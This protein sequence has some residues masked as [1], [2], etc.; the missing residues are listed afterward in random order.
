MGA[1]LITK[2]TKYADKSEEK[3]CAYASGNFRQSN[4]SSLDMEIQGVIYA[5]NKFKLYLNK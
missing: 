2:P 1:R 3:I 5:L 4:W